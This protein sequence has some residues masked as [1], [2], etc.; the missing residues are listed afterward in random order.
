MLGTL[1]QRGDGA[2][3]T[4][5]PKGINI[6]KNQAFYQEQMGKTMEAMLRVACVMAYANQPQTFH[7][8]RSRFTKPQF[9]PLY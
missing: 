5:A 3:A 6:N 1:K 2:R 8:W 9:G 7:W 4:L